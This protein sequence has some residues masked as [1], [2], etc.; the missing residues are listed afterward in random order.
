LL[1][2]IETFGSCYKQLKQVTGSVEIHIVGIITMQANKSRTKTGT[3]FPATWTGLASYERAEKDT[4]PSILPCLL[5]N[6]ALKFPKSLSFEPAVQAFFHLIIKGACSFIYLT[7]AQ[8]LSCAQNTED[9][10]SSPS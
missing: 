10:N 7:H 8:G 1:S 2:S 9:G 5:S 3:M 6:K 4:S